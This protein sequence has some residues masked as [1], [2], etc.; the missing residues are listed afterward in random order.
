MKKWIVLCLALLIG[1]GAAMAQK[2]QKKAP[3]AMKT[4]VFVTNLDC[5]NCA[6]KVE[7]NVPTLGK[8]IKDLKIDLTTREVTVTYDS[9]KCT[10]EQILAGFGK[11]KVE[12]QVKK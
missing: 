1:C 2:P 3:K 6:K 11:L 5:P 4:T 9:S 10:D 8:G 12:A 7:T